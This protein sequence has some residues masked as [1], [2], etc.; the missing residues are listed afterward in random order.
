MD[1][2]IVA[3][4][5]QRPLRTAISILGVSLGVILIVLMVG[6]ARGMVRDSATRQ[7]NVD[8]EIRFTSLELSSTTPANPLMLPERF[9]EAI[10]KGVQPT[11]EDPD[12][13]PKPP[14]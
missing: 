4:V 2:L 3:N 9:A 6:L 10:L 12:I 14:I 7:G 13:T 1:N 8:A 5:K 11:A